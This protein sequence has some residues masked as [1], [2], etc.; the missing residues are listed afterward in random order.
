MAYDYKKLGSFCQ[1]FPWPKKFKW[2]DIQGVGPLTTKDDPD[3]S[4]FTS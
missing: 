3:G 1:H 2:N 4:R